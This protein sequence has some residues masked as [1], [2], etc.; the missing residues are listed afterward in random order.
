M[1]PLDRDANAGAY[2]T[3]GR[4]RPGGNYPLVRPDRA[5]TEVR[6]VS[7]AMAKDLGIA[8]GHRSTW[9]PGDP[10]KIHSSVLVWRRA[11]VWAD[12]GDGQPSSIEADY[13]NRTTNESGCCP[14]S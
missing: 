2:H 8:G 4:F 5:E 11:S 10:V 12:H 14:V 6:V 13:S 3:A 1:F 7:Q 9:K